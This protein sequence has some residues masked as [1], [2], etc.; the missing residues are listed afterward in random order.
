LRFSLLYVGNLVTLGEVLEQA[1][2]DALD[3]GAPGSDCEQSSSS[4]LLVA[5]QGVKVPLDAPVVELWE[6]FHHPD[7]YLYITILQRLQPALSP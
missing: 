3:R 6:H 5:C 7:F 2:P 1:V 4:S